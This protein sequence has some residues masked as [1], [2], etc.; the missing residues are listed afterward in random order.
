VPLPAGVGATLTGCSW[1]PTGSGQYEASGTL[2]N[3]PNTAHG[4]T[5]T[6]HWLQAG[7]EVGQQRAVVDPGPGAA[8][9]WSLSL[10]AP[11]PPAD[12]FSCALSVA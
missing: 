5:I 2:T 1:Q 3:G 6:I 11:T 8:K 9:P 7:R 4:W 12:P 10:G